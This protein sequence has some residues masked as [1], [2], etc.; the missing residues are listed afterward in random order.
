VLPVVAQGAAAAT[1]GALPDRESP[2]VI[3][4][5]ILAAVGAKDKPTPDVRRTAAPSPIPLGDDEAALDAFDAK[6]EHVAALAAI[7]AA[8]ARAPTDAR[9]HRRRGATLYR[10]GRVHEARA[11][12]EHAMSLGS[13]DERTWRQLGWC[14]LWTGNRDEASR[15]MTRA[16]ESDARRWEAHFGMATAAQAAGRLDDAIAGFRRVLELAPDSV[17]ARNCLVVC[18]LD[19]RDS[20]AAQAEARRTIAADDAQPMA[21]ANLGVALGRQLRFDEALPAFERA[22]AL[23][24]ATRDDVDSFVNH[25]NCLRDAGR[26]QEAIAIYERS[27]P[28]RPNV[29]GHGD[30]AFALLTVGRLAEGFREYESRWMTNAFLQRYPQFDRPQWNGQDLHGKTLLLW[31]EQGFGDTFQFIRYAAHVKALGATVLVVVRDGLE[32]VLAGCRGIDRLVRRD[33]PTPYFDYHCPLMSLPRV[34]GTDLDTIPATTPYLRPDDDAMRKWRGRLPETARR[35]VGIVWAGSPAHPNDR[36]RSIALEQLRPVLAIEGVQFVSLQKGPATEAL[37]SLPPGIDIVD[38][39]DQ[40]EDFSD[41]LAV[42]DQLDLVVCVDTSVA[43]LAGA[44]GTPVWVLL[45]FPADFRWLE[46]RTDSPWYPSA[47]LFRQDEQRRWEPVVAQMHEAMAQWV[48]GSRSAPSGEATV[49]IPLRPRSPE[50]AFGEQ[51]RGFSAVTRARY[52]LV[53]Y[54]PDRPIE[55]VSLALYGESRQAQLDCVATLVPPGGTIV[56]AWPGIGTHAIPMSRM[57]GPSGHLLAMEPRHALY[58]VLRQ[59]LAANG[60]F[61]ATALCRGLGAKSAAGTVKSA[62]QADA[63]A[64]GRVMEMEH[65]I[66]RVDDLRLQR[67]DLLRIDDGGCAEDVLAGAGE[68]LWRLRPRLYI[69]VADAAELDAICRQAREFGYRCWRHESPLFGDVNFNRGATDVFMG[70]TTLALVGVPEEVEVSA[71][72]KGCTELA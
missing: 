8:L 31:V 64:T 7:D 68:T 46:R 49:A 19:L 33:E 11:A 25:C 53:Q 42:L 54:F 18:H 23:E 66:D 2:S 6:G 48:G 63:L 17:D 14:H 21:W 62:A 47:R 36:Y 26:M 30:Y 61:N 38:L 13:V 20:A 39:G 55:G 1:I 24:A 4:R 27:L 57:I 40:L 43:H 70:R 50:E 45:P 72:W 41:T 69:D 44:L 22:Q 29:N 16:V 71:A 34:F 51:R 60:V 37:G 56:H 15:C 3:L 52:G 12:T 32:R 59:N 28:A 67:L 10:W 65:A 9:L 58:R 5:R 35:R